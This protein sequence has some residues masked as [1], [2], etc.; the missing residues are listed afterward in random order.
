MVFVSG[1]SCSRFAVLL[2]TNTYGQISGV[3]VV[4]VNYRMYVGLGLELN[5]E[6]GFGWIIQIHNLGLKFGVCFK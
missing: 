6:L 5:L 1:T 3:R 2:V 4:D